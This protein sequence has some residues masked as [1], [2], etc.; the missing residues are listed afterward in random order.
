VNL[1]TRAILLGCAVLLLGAAGLW[2]GGAFERIWAALALVWLLAVLVEGRWARQVPIDAQ[3]TLPAKPALGQPHAVRIELVHGGPRAL[4]LDVLLPVPAGALG[5]AEVR[6]VALPAGGEV[7]AL[8]ERFTPV[9]LGALAGTPASGRLLGRFG[10]AWW[11]R[12]LPAPA[13]PMQ[14]APDTLHAD[15]R[16]AP[17][18]MRG[19]EALLRRGHGLELLGLREYRPGDPM[20]ALAWKASARAANLMVRDT[21]VDQHLEVALVIDVGRTSAIQA[22]ALSRLHHFVNLAA[23]FGERCVAFGDRLNLVAF[24]G[25]IAL[26]LTGLQ[27]GSGLRRL[28]AALAR[29]RTDPVESSPVTAALEVRR[30]LR[31]RGLVVWLGDVDTADAGALAAVAGVLSPQHLALF[32]QVQDPEVLAELTRPAQAW[33]DPYAALAAQQLVQQQALAA[34]RLS[35]LGCE[36]VAAPPALLERQLLD[37]YRRLR[38]RRRV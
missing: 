5:H 3:W 23:R 2:V 31:H 12:A 37:Q 14:V 28:R 16:E 18:G 38:A 13:E 35:R 10:L 27:G 21:L 22:G 30:L 33:L 36:V 34:R 32:A 8:E 17:G 24:A 26:S 25:G 6:R 29:L 7:R 11:T 1:T 20:R 15:E 4:L 19:E 9:A